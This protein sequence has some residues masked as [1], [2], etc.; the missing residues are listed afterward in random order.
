MVEIK[1]NKSNENQRL[2]KYLLKFFNKAPK[3]FIYKMLRKKYIKL[4]N[5]K[6][7]GNE[8][9]FNNDIISIYLSDETISNFKEDKNIQKTNQDFKILFEDENIILCYKPINLVSQPDVHNKNNSLNDQ[10]IFYMYKNGEYTKS[11]DF[12]PSICNRLDKNTSGIIAFGKNFKSLQALNTLFKENLIEKYYLTAVYG[13]VTKPG[14]IELYH[15]KEGNKAILSKE[16]IPNSKKIITKY[17]P[18]T[19]KDGKTLLNIQLI[20]GKTHQIRASLEY[21]GY[22]IIGD[23]KYNNNKNNTDFDL[24]YQFLHCYKIYFKNHT[25]YLDYL[26]E[27]T[28]ICGYMDKSF[29][30][31]LNYFNY[32]IQN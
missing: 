1:I 8:I 16:Y 19:V 25:G 18:I 6:A 7:S 27:K 4:N 26:S 15:K 2:D 32:K 12:T 11:S 20:T 13:N 24:K 29:Q 21:T 5:K 30:N 14:I 31:I 9:I 10:L 3:S 22:P 28:F 23:K 17:E